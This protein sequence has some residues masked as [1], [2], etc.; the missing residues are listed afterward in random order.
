M[1]RVLALIL[2]PRAHLAFLFDLEV[3]E[4][5][6]RQILVQEPL[7]LVLL[8]GAILVEVGRVRIKHV[9]VRLR[10]ACG[11]VKGLWI[12]HLL[13]TV[14]LEEL[15]ILVLE[16]FFIDDFQFGVLEAAQVV[17]F[18]ADFSLLNLSFHDQLLL[19][20]HEALEGLLLLFNVH[21]RD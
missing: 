19:L 2:G 12:H 8:V 1:L 21:E 14:S 17:G 10:R 4:V 15:L 11:P 6:F 7:I 20:P 3:Q 13:E 18:V 9:Q 5:H 16:V